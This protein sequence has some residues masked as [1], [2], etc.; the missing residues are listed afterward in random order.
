MTAAVVRDLVETLGVNLAWWESRDT[1]PEPAGTR[2]AANDAVDAI[3]GAMRELHQIREQLT[4]EMRA[5]DDAA[6][7]RVDALLAR[8]R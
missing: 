8:L 6:A 3:D 1:C 7:K 2:G 5:Y 4:G